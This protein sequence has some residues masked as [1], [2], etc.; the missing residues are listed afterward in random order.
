MTYD[1]SPEDIKKSRVPHEVF[2]TNLIFNH[3]LV[4]VAIISASSLLHFIVIIPIFSVVSLVY[5]FWGA[6]R[7]KTNASWYVSG[8][9]QIAARRSRFFLLMLLAIGSIFAI[10]WTASG[11]DMGPQQWAL[12][13]AAFLPMMVSVLAMVIFESESLHQAKSAILPDWVSERFPENA[14]TPIEKAQA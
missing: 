13:G 5:I 10:I 2:L 11:G 4:F 1:V 6:H 12:G 9:W 3:I 7:A 14:M 8:H